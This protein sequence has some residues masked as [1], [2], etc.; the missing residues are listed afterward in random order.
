VSIIVIHI[1]LSGHYRRI[2]FE[3]WS[4]LVD[5]YGVDGYALA[6]RGI[7]LDDL[8]RWRVFKNSKVDMY[9][10]YYTYYMDYMYYYVYYYMYYMLYGGYSKTPR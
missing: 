10:M 3:A 5:L 9:Y 8:T 2:S 6:V 4:A 7:P 1:P